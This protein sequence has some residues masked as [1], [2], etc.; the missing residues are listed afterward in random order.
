[1]YSLGITL[2]EIFTGRSPTDDMFRDGMSLHSFAEASLPDK[3]MDIADSNIWLHEGLHSE[4]DTTHT[5][6][7]KECLSSVI[8]LGVL[9]SRHLPI[10]RLS[11]SDAAA[12]MHSIR[13]LYIATEHFGSYA[14]STKI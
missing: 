13:D 4:N 12:E 11:V 2:I 6:R 3:V 8:K 10:E 5:T 1:M 14:D 7:I 9:C